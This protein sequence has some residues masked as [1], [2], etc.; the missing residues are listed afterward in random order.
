MTLKGSNQALPTPRNTVRS[1]QPAYKF[2]TPPFPS[3]AILFMVIGT[4]ICC[5]LSSRYSEDATSRRRMRSSLDW[6]MVDSSSSS[7]E[8]SVGSK[9]RVLATSNGVVKNAHKHAL[10]M[11]G[12]GRVKTLCSCK[13]SSTRVEGRSTKKDPNYSPIVIVSNSYFPKFSPPVVI[14]ALRKIRLNKNGIS[15]KI[16]AGSSAT[17]SFAQSPKSLLTFLS[18]KTCKR[19]AN[20]SAGVRIANEAISATNAASKLATN[21]PYDAATPSLSPGNKF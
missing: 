14:A 2:C 7:S 8:G 6:R 13:S 15:V 21:A 4:L 5:R 12:S 19:S 9:I 1:N 11:N 10:E 16:I 20:T 3:A 17:L 18:P